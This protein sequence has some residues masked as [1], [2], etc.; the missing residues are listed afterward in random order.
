[1]RRNG[2]TTTGSKQCYTFTPRYSLVCMRIPK[3]PVVFQHSQQPGAAAA[4][5]TGRADS[6]LRSFLKEWQ[7]HWLLSSNQSGGF[8]VLTQ[9]N[10]AWKHEGGCPKSWVQPL[11]PKG[12]DPSPALSV[13][14][15]S[16]VFSH[17]EQ[18]NFHF[19][20]PCPPLNSGFCTK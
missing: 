14:P 13:F 7:R 12:L 20:C 19:T 4:L 2:P 3:L 10:R 17:Q 8:W 16:T 11:I 1:M 15:P 6:K 18:I 5:R 9:E